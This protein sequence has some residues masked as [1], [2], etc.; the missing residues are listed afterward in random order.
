MMLLEEVKC[1]IWWN[2]TVFTVILNDSVEIYG[3]LSV[4]N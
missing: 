1:L 4:L 2:A 3:Y